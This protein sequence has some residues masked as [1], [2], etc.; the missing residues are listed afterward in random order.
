VVIARPAW[1]GKKPILVFSTPRAGTN[2]VCSALGAYLR[3]RGMEGLRELF[4]LWHT[5][6][7]DTGSAIRW[8]GYLENV[9][10]GSYPREFVQAII[11]YRMGLIRKYHGRYFFKVFPFQIDFEN[12][13]ELARSYH[14]VCLERRDL[15]E[16]ALSLAFATSTRSFVRMPGEPAQ[17]AAPGSLEADL[18]Q[19]DA[20]ESQI[21]SYRAWRKKLDLRN[22]CYYEDLSG[23]GSTAEI[24]SSVLGVESPPLSDRTHERQVL[25]RKLD[26]FRNADEIIRWYRSSRLQKLAPIELKPGKR[27]PK[28]GPLA[29]LVVLE[30]L[31]KDGIRDVA[32]RK[33]LER[34][35]KALPKERLGVAFSYSYDVAG[36]KFLP[37]NLELIRIGN[38]L[39]DAPPSTRF[40]ELRKVL[41]ER[42]PPVVICEDSTGQFRKALVMKSRPLLASA[43]RPLRLTSIAANR[44]LFAA[45][46]DEESPAARTIRRFFSPCKRVNLEALIVDER[47]RPE[48]LQRW[49]RV[50][51][52]CPEVTFHVGPALEALGSLPNVVVGARR[53]CK[54]IHVVLAKDWSAGAELLA[55]ALESRRFA[56]ASGRREISALFPGTYLRVSE[57]LRSE[58][59]VRWLRRLLGKHAYPRDF[60][61]EQALPLSDSPSFN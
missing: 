2:F 26:A 50:A 22:V 36:L 23:L 12:F 5:S 51:R 32:V 47:C 15:F 34:V 61:H 28:P 11:N 17:S 56:V 39:L 10:Q 21:L 55:E 59:Y 1:D 7:W 46:L 53:L 43:P 13:S 27:S 52:S 16:Q 20:M 9:D 6:V 31:S 42:R 18:N 3:P 24:V 8:A 29:A 57:R 49:R 4:G 33:Q 48:D 41:R 37:E 25:G 40:G 44:S 45:F 35:C 14:V 58:E 19:L 30:A 60:K 38:P 54:G